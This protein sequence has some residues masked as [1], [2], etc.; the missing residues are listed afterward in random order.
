MAACSQR[1]VSLIK[2]TICGI[3]NETGMPKS[4]LLF[5][6]LAAGLAIITGVVVTDLVRDQNSLDTP[7][8]EGT[9]V[10][11]GLPDLKTKAEGKQ[12]AARSVLLWD[13]ATQSIRYEQN[14]FERLPIASI[15]KLMTA[16]V[17][18]DHGIDWDKTGGI[19][20]REYVLGGQLLLHPGEE[21]TMRDLFVASLLGSANNATLAY[22]RHTGI[23]T[24]DFVIE[25]NRKAVAI[26]LEQTHFVEVTGLDQDNVS[27]AYEVARLAEYAFTNYPEI[28]RATSQ[29]EY[30][31]SLRGSDRVHTIH[32]TNK[33]I[34]ELGE[35]YSGSKT[36]YL[37]EAAYCLV[38]QG[39]GASHNLIGVILGSPS[40]SDHF[41]S[42][43]Q[44]LQSFT[45]APL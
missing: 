45:S 31:F 9:L 10:Q 8:V 4:T 27:T 32:N 40:E 17:A 19:E 41:F 33:L 35:T 25:M 37:Y 36:G 18:L 38:V 7:R 6:C 5:F 30:T 44:L 22:V 39:E 24:K 43:R 20:L 42:M 29:K 15:T 34:S 26:G 21:A 3:R 11:L 16:M 13:Q 28:A 2:C 23:P 14:G 12:Y 1:E